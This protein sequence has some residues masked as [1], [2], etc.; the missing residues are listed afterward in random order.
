MQKETLYLESRHKQCRRRPDNFQVSYPFSLRRSRESWGLPMR[1][2]TSPV[3]GTAASTPKPIYV[4]ANTDVSFVDSRRSVD[5]WHCG[6]RKVVGSAGLMLRTCSPV[7]NMGHLF[8]GDSLAS[9][10]QVLRYGFLTTKGTTGG[11]SFE[12]PT[13]RLSSA[14]P[15]ATAVRSQYIGQYTDLYDTIAHQQH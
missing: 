10:S 9:P 15:A 13:E 5:P 12:A 6:R 14:E 3:S 4:H 1:G 11:V 2:Y 8:H 7:Q